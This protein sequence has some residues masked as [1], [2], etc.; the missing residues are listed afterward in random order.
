MCRKPHK[1]P[2]PV[3]R[4]TESN[5]AGEG[6]RSRPQHNVVTDS[7]RFLTRLSIGFNMPYC[8]HYNLGIVY[9]VTM[10]HAEAW[11]HGKKQNK[12][13]CSR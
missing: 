13:N 4:N 10:Y 6:G 9:I 12:I 8:Y 7:I 5:L 11:K 1:A 2:F 3:L